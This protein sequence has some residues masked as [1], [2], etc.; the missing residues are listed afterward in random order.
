MK[1]EYKTKNQ[2]IDELC[3]YRLQ[4]EDLKSKHLKF[5]DVQERLFREKKRANEADQAKREFM[6]NLNHV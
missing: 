2:L 3:Q 5:S 1:D 4:L 6:A